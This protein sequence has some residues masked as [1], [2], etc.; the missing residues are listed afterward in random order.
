[1]SMTLH[2][3][4]PRCIFQNNEE[5]VGSLQ[6]ILSRQWQSV[7]FSIDYHLGPFYN[8]SRI[9]FTLKRIQD[10]FMTRDL[11]SAILFCAFLSSQAKANNQLQTQVC[12]YA[13]PVFSTLLGTSNGKRKQRNGSLFQPEK[14]PGED[15]FRLRFFD[16][17][18]LPR[19]FRLRHAMRSLKKAA[20]SYL[21]TPSFL[22]FRGSSKSDSWP[23]RS[24]SDGPT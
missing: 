20:N 2:S 15:R 10:Q 16:P 7:R 5:I 13:R 8:R 12:S 21:N 6:S 19:E 3:S 1:M 4:L 11:H 14:V 22:S 18:F 24:I 17:S 9:L 23:I